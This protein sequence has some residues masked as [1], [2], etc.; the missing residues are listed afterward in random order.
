M[1]KQIAE[2]RVVIAEITPANPNVYY[3][4][5]Y[6]DALRK[7][8]ILIADK[9]IKETP[10]RHSPVQDDLLRKQHRRQAACRGDLLNYL[11]TIMGTG[12]SASA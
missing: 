3:E 4:I 6:A 8:L 12:P 1:T 11:N 9:T 2:Y 7:P 5:G 10:V